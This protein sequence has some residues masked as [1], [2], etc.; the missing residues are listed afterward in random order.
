MRHR[1]DQALTVQPQE[2]AAA[3]VSAT[4]GSTPGAVFLT[5]AR[6][7]GPVNRPVGSGA[8]SRRCTPTKSSRWYCQSTIR[9]TS[10]QG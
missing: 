8:P 1:L 5:A 4:S 2:F 9:R 10:A 3:P 6:D 7:A